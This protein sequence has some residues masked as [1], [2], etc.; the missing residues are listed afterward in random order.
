M[1]YGFISKFNGL[2]FNRKKV[3]ETTDYQICQSLKKLTP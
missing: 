2:I 1:T 3:Y